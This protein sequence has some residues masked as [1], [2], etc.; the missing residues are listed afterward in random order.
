MAEAAQP[1]QI[2]VSPVPPFDP[3][4]DVTAVYQKWQRWVKGFEIF[5]DAAGCKDAVQRRQLL[6]H[7]AGADVQDIFFTI[8]PE[9]ADYDAAKQALNTYF[10]PVK[11]LPYQ[12]HLFRQTSQQE[13]EPM[14]QFVTR[15]RQIAK[16]CDYGAETDGFIRDQII[17]KCAC[18]KLR[19]KLLAESDLTLKKCIEIATAKEL[20]E[21]QAS[22]FTTDDKVFSISSKKHSKMQNGEIEGADFPPYQ[23]HNQRLNYDPQK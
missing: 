22:E 23:R 10:K 11:N 12:R 8:D 6:L 2:N 3:H 9:P 17:E 16:D 13:G 7:S 4:G 21:K 5:A 18:S 20:S 1:V 14:N 19:T 15:L